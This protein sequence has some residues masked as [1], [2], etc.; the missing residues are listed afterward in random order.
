MTPEEDY[1]V[2]P[3]E[4]DIEELA[5]IFVRYASIET[6]TVARTDVPALLRESLKTFGGEKELNIREFEHLVL[7]MLKIFGPN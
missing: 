7:E 5:E 2:P 3:S 1:I 6:D 4:V